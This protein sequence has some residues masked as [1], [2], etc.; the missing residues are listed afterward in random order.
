MDNV[1]LE[2]LERIYEATGLNILGDA[3]CSPDYETGKLE[4][5]FRQEESERTIMWP[6]HLIQCDC[7]SE[8]FKENPPATFLGHYVYCLEPI[9]NPLKDC[10]AMVKLQEHF[11]VN[12]AHIAALNEWEGWIKNADDSLEISINGKTINEAVILAVVESLR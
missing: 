12:L 10:Y 3:L 6:V 7:D 5:D 8:Y 2:D 1:T 4:V 11:K 9:P